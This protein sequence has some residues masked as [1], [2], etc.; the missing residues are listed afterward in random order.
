MPPPL[1]QTEDLFKNLVLLAEEK[2]LLLALAKSHCDAKAKTFDDFVIGKGRGIVILLD[3]PP[4]I[5]KTLTAESVAE[6]IKAPLYTISAGELGS[7]SHN[8]EKRLSDIL[9]MASIWNAV[10]LIDEAD[11]FIEQRTPYEL[12]RNELVAIFLR[13]MEYFHGVMILT[14]NRVE[15]MDV[16]FDSRVD[17]RLHYLPL[18]ASS[19]RQIWANFLAR[20]PEKSTFTDAKLDQ[21]AKLDLN[22]RQIKSA[23]KTA[24]LL[25]SRK[26]EG[27][28]IEHVGTVLRITRGVLL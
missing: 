26:G 2:D 20:L 21:L 5:G 15:T 6:I 12:D 8:V 28:K 9:E 13:H 11:I 23:I 25:P 27:V 3:G 22:R 14:T 7:Q 18:P 17:I 4:G 19:C 10:L 1:R 16:V 24:Q